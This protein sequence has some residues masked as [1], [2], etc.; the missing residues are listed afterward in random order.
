MEVTALVVVMVGNGDVFE[1]TALVPM[2][3]M[4]AMVA[5]VITTMATNL[6]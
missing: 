3:A 5:M 1:V 4:A 6:R 2:A